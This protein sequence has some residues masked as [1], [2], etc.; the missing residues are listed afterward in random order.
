MCAIF[1]VKPRKLF[2]LNFKHNTIEKKDCSVMWKLIDII[3]KYWNDR[4]LDLDPLSGTRN[5][6]QSM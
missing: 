6:V 2:R 5:T 4:P 3:C 1:T